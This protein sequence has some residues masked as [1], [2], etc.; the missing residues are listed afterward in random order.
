MTRFIE[1]SSIGV[2]K[3]SQ[4]RA[5]KIMGTMCDNYQDFESENSESFFEFAHQL[6][7]KRW[8]RLREVV[9]GSEVFSLPE[10][11]KE[12]CLFHGEYTEAYPGN[13][14][15]LQIRHYKRS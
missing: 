12:Y 4:I 5:A 6:M 10:Y 14:S 9:E 11:P 7:A 8:K 15:T 13:T 2:S 3:D 1:L